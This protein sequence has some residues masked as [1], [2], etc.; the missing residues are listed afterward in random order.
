MPV[1][2]GIRFKCASK[3]KFKFQLRTKN[4]NNMKKNLHVVL[5]FILESN[6]G[7]TL[8]S[9]FH[10]DALL[11]RCLKIGDITLRS[12]PVLCLLLRDLKR[13]QSS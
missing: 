11:G 9:S 2:L 1:L 7:Y 3:I 10:I 13:Q 5:G 6:L 4:N 12:A 8:K